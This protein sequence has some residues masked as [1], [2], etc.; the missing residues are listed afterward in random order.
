MY[1]III[2]NGT[3][4]DG[5]GNPMYRADIGIKENKI[6]KI[7]QLQNEKWE[8]EIDATGKLVCPGFVDVNNHSDAYWQIFIN[9]DLE[10][11]VYQ[12]ITTIVGGNCGSSLAPHPVILPPQAEPNARN[13]MTSNNCAAA[14]W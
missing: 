14:N 1:D 11:L 6:A 5:T 3:I 4:I 2:K 10:S 8:V 9:P 7:G 12:G 13:P